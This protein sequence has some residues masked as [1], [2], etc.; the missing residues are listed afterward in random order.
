M[1][2]ILISIKPKYVADILNGKKTIEIRK[3]M[4]KVIVGLMWR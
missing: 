3:T 4:P 1:K 2:A